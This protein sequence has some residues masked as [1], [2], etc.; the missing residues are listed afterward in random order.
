MK[1]FQG[2]SNNYNNQHNVN[3]G[4]QGQVNYLIKFYS[5]SINTN[6]AVTFN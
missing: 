5:S 6:V 3:R 2:L 4:P 1:S